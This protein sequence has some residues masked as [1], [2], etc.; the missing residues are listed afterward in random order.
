MK[1]F[2]PKAFLLARESRGLT[3]KALAE[4]LEM[5]QGMVSKIQD[6]IKDF[7]TDKLPKLEEALGYPR[8]FYSKDWSA[9]DASPLYRKQASV[10]NPHLRKIEARMSLMKHWVAELIDGIDSSPA[11]LP[12]LKPDTFQNGPIGVAQSLRQYLGLSSGPVPSVVKAIEKLGCVI[13]PFDFETSKISAC[14]EWMGEVPVIFMNN[15]ACP[16]RKRMTLAHELGHLIMHK[17]DLFREDAEDEAYAFAQEFT[18]P[19][20]EIKGSLYGIDLPKLSQL[21]LRWKMSIQALIYRAS[22]LGCISSYRNRQLWSMINARQYRY[23]E[24]FED[25]IPMEPPSLLKHLISLYT[26]QLGYSIDELGKKLSIAPSDVV[27]QLIAEDRFKIVENENIP[28]S[29][30]NQPLTRN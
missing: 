23:E 17:N 7:P 21:K 18:M 13:I 2:N 20:K 3:Q 12:S 24:P 14:S 22:V 10:G 26:D 5:T 15:T 19:A 11:K 6:G 1:C 29:H 30:G 28:S 9:S 25:R 27:K 16:S 8:D 4:R